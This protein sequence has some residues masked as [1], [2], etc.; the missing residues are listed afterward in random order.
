MLF[1]R[2]ARG[3][4]REMKLYGEGKKQRKKKRFSR[5]WMESVTTLS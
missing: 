5:V 1:P 4:Y 2:E 3:I